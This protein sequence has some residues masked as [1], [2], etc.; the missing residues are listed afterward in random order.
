MRNEE[1]DSHSRRTPHGDGLR[2]TAVKFAVVDAPQ[3]VL[4]PVAAEAEVED[5]VGAGESEPLLPARHVPRLPV[6]ET[7]VAD[8]HDLP[9]GRL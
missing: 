3:D 6:V 9:P 2:R 8:Q 5:V 4:R 7:V 1:C